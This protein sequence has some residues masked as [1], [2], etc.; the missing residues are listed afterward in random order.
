MA[1]SIASLL[2]VDKTKIIY[3]YGAR[4]SNTAIKEICRSSRHLGKHI[5]STPLEHASVSGCLT[6]L[7]ERGYKIELV[8]VG[9]QTCPL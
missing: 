2:N 6:A 8:R 4:K 5:F 7:Q 9:I 1:A 3:T